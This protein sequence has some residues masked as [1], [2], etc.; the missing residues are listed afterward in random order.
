ME[1]PDL[2]KPTMMWTPTRQNTNIDILRRKIN[3]KYEV[4]L[5]NYWSFHDWSIENYADF[6]KEFWDFA[7]IIHSQPYEQ[8]IDT[9]KKISEIPQWFKGARL[10]FAEN[11]LRYKDNKIALYVTGEGMNPVEEV[12]FAELYNRVGAYAAAMKKLGVKKGDRV[13]G[14]LPNGQEAVEAMLAAASLGAIW[15]STSP[16]FGVTGV[17]DRFLQIRPKLIFSVDKVVYNGK[18]HDHLEKLRLVVQGLSDIE[19][20]IVIQLKKTLGSGES[21]FSSVPKSCS[22]EDFLE[23]GKDKEGNIPNLEFVQVPFNHPLCILYSSGTTGPP[24]CMVHSHGGTLIKHLEEHL[25]QGNMDRNDVIMYYTTTGWMMWNWMVTALAV[26]ASLVLYD[27]SPFIPSPSAMWDLVDKTGITIFGISAK[28][29]AAVEAKEVKPRETHSLKTLHTILSTGSPLKPQSYDYVYKHIKSDILLGSI[30]GGSDI[31]ACFA[32]QNPTLPVHRGEI[33]SQHLG[34][35][36][37]CWN[38]EGKAVTGEKGELICTKPFP[39]MP[40]HFWNDPEGKRYQQ[41]YFRKFSGVWCHGDFCLINPETK[42][43][44]ML[45]RSDATLN[46]NG[47]RFGSAEIYHVVE[48]ISEIQD[49]LCVSHFDRN[50]EEKVI[51]FL[52]MASGQVKTDDLIG[53]VKV[54]IRK[55]L[56]PRHV[57][58]L[59]LEIKDIPYTINGKKIEVAVK[60]I[61]SGR[62]I[63][64]RGFLENPQSLDL[65]RN[66]PEL[67][68]F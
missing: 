43:I 37:E 50:G 39:S 2:T 45:G 10:N 33:Q 12:T 25:L 20:V 15:S 55:E 5:E 8:V 30:T 7:G 27:G 57:P 24:K 58:A 48:S 17:L 21:Q 41:A 13:V 31:V 32:G 16:D 52:K 56:S 18:L 59:I 46:P 22:L 64:D 9:T 11:L 42:G 38:S 47:V 65:F 66:I 68:E 35:A 36:F 54:A 1:Q 28:W 51:L 61:L 19:K 3:A 53:R 67:Q 4:K 60:E 49:S 63:K 62:N 6:W 40:T 29:L 26:G 44:L 34:I 14:Y 23:V